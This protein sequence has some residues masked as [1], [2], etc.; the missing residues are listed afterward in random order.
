[1]EPVCAKLINQR[2]PLPDGNVKAHYPCALPNECSHM[3]EAHAASG[4]AHDRDLVLNSIH[5]IDLSAQG[6]L[7]GVG[8]IDD[9]FAATHV[10]RFIRGEENDGGTDLFR[11][12][13][14]LEGQVVGGW[15]RT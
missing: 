13:P 6:L 11:L 12:R 8:A 15:Q 10:G 4:T 5:L 3:F 2:G 14:S 7:G 9:K 1:M